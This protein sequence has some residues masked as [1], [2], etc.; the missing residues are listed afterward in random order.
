MLQNLAISQFLWEQ[1]QNNTLIILFPK[2]QPLPES[3]AITTSVEDDG[4]TFSLKI[5]K[6][7]YKSR[8]KYTCEADEKTTSSHI[9]F[10]GKFSRNIIF[11]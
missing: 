6:P 4:M 3:K 5:D 1:F 9:D 11:Q 8:G 2:F 7:T 10:D